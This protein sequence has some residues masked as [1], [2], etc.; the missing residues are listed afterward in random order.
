MNLFN[1]L[2]PICSTQFAPPRRFARG[3][4][5][6]PGKVPP[7]RGKMVHFPGKNGE[8]G[9]KINISSGKVP[10][11]CRNTVHFPLIERTR[12][13]GRMAAEAIVLFRP[14]ES[15]S[16]SRKFGSLSPDRMDEKC[17]QNGRRS[18]CPIS[19]QGK[20]PLIRGNLVHFP[21]QRANFPAATGIGSAG[22][23]IFIICGRQQFFLLSAITIVHTNI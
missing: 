18:D 6:P 16:D 2:H 8:N 17:R 9:G 11:I 22:H 12:N 13:A 4:N 20:V 3:S 10:G 19:S 14:R 15:A 23:R 5:I 7:I 21:V 1:L